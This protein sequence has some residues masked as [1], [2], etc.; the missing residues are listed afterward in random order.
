M[1]LNVKIKLSRGMTAPEYAT[2]GSA[3]V[4][5][6]AAL[7][8]DEVITLCPGERARIPTGIAISPER[9]DVVAVIAGRSGHGLKHGVTMAN[10]IGVID[11]DYRGEISV[12]LINHGNEPFEVRRGD[13]IAQMM[14]MPVLAANFL[15]VDELDETERGA[16]GFG[17]TG[18]K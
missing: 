7:E 6:R 4:D 5:L 17:H 12:V 2:D 11:S 18:I 9:Q 1:S 3:A 15:T 13:R 8:E 10:S 14:F 16:G